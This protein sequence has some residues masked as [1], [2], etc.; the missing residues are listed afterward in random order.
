[1]LYDKEKD[2]WSGPNWEVLQLVR[3]RWGLQLN[4]TF[5][6]RGSNALVN[7]VVSRY[8]VHVCRLCAH[9]ARWALRA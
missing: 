9:T 5:V 3:Q 6:E 4:L 2:T 7:D 1:M 8:L